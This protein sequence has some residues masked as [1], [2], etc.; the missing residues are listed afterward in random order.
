MELNTCKTNCFKQFVRK[1]TR[2]IKEET[3]YNDETIITIVDDFIST[4]IVKDHNVNAKIL[5]A[6]VYLYTTNAL[7]RMKQPNRIIAYFK[8]NIYFNIKRW[9]RNPEVARQQIVTRSQI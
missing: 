9:K 7:E 1:L 3:N 5:H 6:L 4:W 2:V 8:K